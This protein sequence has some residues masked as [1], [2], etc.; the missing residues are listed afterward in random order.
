MSSAFI[1]AKLVNCSPLPLLPGPLSVF[2][3]N[4]FVSTSNLKLV[5]PGEEFRC[6]LGVDPAIK[7][8]YKRANTSNEQF[9]FMTKKSLSTHEQAI[10]LRNAKANQSV[11]ITIREP[12]PKAVD[13][14]VKVNLE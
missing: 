6:L 8:E 9:G 14:Q 5:L 7:V 1:N 13:D 4:S 12:V 3:N 10:S 2:F 11:Q